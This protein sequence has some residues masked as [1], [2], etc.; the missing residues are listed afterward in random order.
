M[1]KSWVII[2]AITIFIV[3][4]FL[5]RKITIGPFKKEYGEKRRKLW[6]QRTFYWQDVIYFSTAITFLILVALKWGNI[7]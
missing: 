1:E 5:F 7:I 2:L 3:V 6:G 4:T